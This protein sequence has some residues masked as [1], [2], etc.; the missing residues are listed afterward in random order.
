MSN[1]SPAYVKRVTAAFNGDKTGV[2]GDMQA[3]IEAVLFDKEAR[4]LPDKQGEGGK[5]REPL[6]RVI[7]ALRQLKVSSPDGFYANTGTFIQQQTGQH[8]LSA[9]SVF[10]FFLPS[11]SP[12]GPIA[13]AGLVAPE[14]QITNRGSIVTASNM[15]EAVLFGNVTNDLDRPPFSKAEF[16]FSDFEALAMKPKKLLKRLDLVMTY[17]TMSKQPRNHIRSTIGQIDDPDTRLRLALFLVYFSPDYA[18]EL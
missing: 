4:A 2:R 13:E 17:G 1:P 7:A 11:H 5:L 16:D 8:P 12:I 6:L 18:V 14:F 10:N 15:L 3:V 9:P